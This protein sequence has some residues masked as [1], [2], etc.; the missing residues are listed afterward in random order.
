MY[1][2]IYSSNPWESNYK[3]GPMGHKNNPLYVA[4]EQQCY[5]MATS[6]TYTCICTCT[7][8]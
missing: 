1:M 2:Y 3:D 4:G 6:A 7:C 8:Y 5:N